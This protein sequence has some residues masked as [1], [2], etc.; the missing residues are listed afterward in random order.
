MKLIPVTNINLQ[1]PPILQVSNDVETITVTKGKHLIVTKNNEKN[2]SSAIDIQD[3]IIDACN[4]DNTTI[5]ITKTGRVKKF[6]STKVEKI[7]LDINATVV[8]VIQKTK[9]IVIGTKEGKIVILND[10]KP[11]KFI[12]ELKE[13]ITKLDVT[14]K[15]FIVATC[16]NSGILYVINSK[17]LKKHT[18]DLEKDYITAF[19]LYNGRYAVVGTVDGFVLYVSLEEKVVLATIRVEHIISYIKSTSSGVFIGT[20]SGQLLFCE[21]SR[22]GIKIV[23]QESVPG[24]VNSIDIQN[25]KLSVLCGR[26]EIQGSFYRNKT[27]KNVIVKYQIK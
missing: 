14:L 25:N 4:F 22:E 12:Y 13:S 27:F 7:K 23:L 26:E 17:T 10:Y 5:L 2:C 6:E 16:V 8:S 1:R 21:I 24:V 9:N 15:N 3:T 18:I 20:V 19:D 11:M